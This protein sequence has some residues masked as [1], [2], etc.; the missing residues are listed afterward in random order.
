MVNAFKYLFN[1]RYRFFIK[2]IRSVQRTIWDNEFK[3][4]K[5]RQVREG[6]RQDRDK[7]V[8]ALQQIEVMLKS[9]E[10][11]KAVLVDEVLA[12]IKEDQ[13]KIADD[14]QRYERQMIMLD[15]EIYGAP[16][17]GEDPGQQGVVDTLKALTE[18]R[19]MY[20]DYANKL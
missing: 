12:K 7:T 5:T 6:V 11:G 4:A 20:S 18:L 9:H 13:A 16:A 3:I 14:K 19:E 17:Q 10:E 1:S 8:E 15:R 2:K